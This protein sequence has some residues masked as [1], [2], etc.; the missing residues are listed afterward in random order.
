MVGYLGP[1]EKFHEKLKLQNFK[2]DAAQEQAVQLIQKLYD[3]L[4]STPQLKPSL[5][6]KIFKKKHLPV[7]GLYFWGG[8]GRGKTFLM[9][10]FFEVLPIDKKRRIHFHR[11]MLDIHEQLRVLPKTP[12]PLPIVAKMIAKDVRVLCLDEFHVHDITDAMLLTGLFKS[13]FENG[14]TLFAT[15]NVKINDLYKNGLQ[16]DLFL[17]TIDYLNSNTK[18]FELLANEDFRLLQLEKSGTYHID[19]NLEKIMSDHFQSLAPTNSKYNKDII[20]NHR[21]I[22]TLALSDD[23]VWFD[24]KT[25]CMEAHAAL[26]YLEIAQIFHTLLLSDVPVLTESEDDSAKRFIH[27]IDALYDH[28]VKLIVTATVLPFDVYTGKRLKFAFERTIS[29]LTEMASKKY[30]ALPHI[31]YN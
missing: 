31:I 24:F 10:C 12:N 5:F 19:G 2:Y 18:E 29:R 4:L 30:L 26:D 22:N 8:V 3:D 13:L 9:D 15:S 23:V 25:I 6:H 7:C 11:F 14:V 17:P 16:R 1:I 28:K 21:K 27:L 20:I